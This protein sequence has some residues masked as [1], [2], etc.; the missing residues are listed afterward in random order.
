M[1]K[2]IRSLVCKILSIVRPI[3]NYRYFK[4][5]W[6]WDL[7]QE[8]HYKSMENLY[9]SYKQFAKVTTILESSSTLEN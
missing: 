2:M 9:S 4:Y 5:D 8:F 3:W 6:T 1:P 7:S